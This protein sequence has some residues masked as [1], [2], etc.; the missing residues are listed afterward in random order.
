MCIMC[1]PILK[2]TQLRSI[3]QVLETNSFYK[4]THLINVML[5]YIIHLIKHRKRDE[6]SNDVIISLFSSTLLYIR[7]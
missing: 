7:L 5:M 3:T 2:G 1:I 4:T 6:I